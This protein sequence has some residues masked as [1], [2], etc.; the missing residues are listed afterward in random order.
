MN[1]IHFLNHL[2]TCK[3]FH[4]FCVI[5]DIDILL[6]ERSLKE[7]VL[8]S[9][10]SDMEYLRFW[11]EFFH[12]LSKSPTL[13]LNLAI[14][15]QRNYWKTIYGFFMQ[16][17]GRVSRCFHRNCLLCGLD[18]H[19]DSRW[20]FTS[21]LDVAW[22]YLYWWNIKYMNDLILIVTFS[23]NVMITLL[24]KMSIDWLETSS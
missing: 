11:L 21:M 22:S 16:V 18:S 5:H 10:D 12:S 1:W 17:H 14:G 2:N 15:K 13:S 23:P 20:L 7:E 8:R 6:Y 9:I 4:S 24:W 3:Q 19:D